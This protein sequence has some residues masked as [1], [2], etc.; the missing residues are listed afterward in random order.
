[1]MFENI[2]RIPDVVLLEERIMLPEGPGVF[3]LNDVCVETVPG[4]DSLA[5]ALT[6]SA[7]PVR[8][9]RLRWHFASRLRA[10]VLGDAWERS[11]ADLAWQTILPWQT[12]PWYAL[13]HADNV[14][15][16]WGVEGRPAA[17]CSWQIDPEGGTLW[18]DVRG[19]GD[20]V[21]LNGR[22]LLAAEVVCREYSAQKQI[23]AFLFRVYNG[24]DK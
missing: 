5:V 16:G 23:D 2:E 6:A 22:R 13:V 24:R 15:A 8:K 4:A 9:I 20:G 17:I 3:R 7:T 11:Y 1:M 18:V 21:L 14:T 10:R 12:L 19:G